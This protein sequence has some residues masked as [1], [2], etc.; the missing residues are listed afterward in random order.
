MGEYVLDVEGGSAFCV[1]FFSAWYEDGGLRAV[2]I[3]DGENGVIS[4][5]FREFSDEI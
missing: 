2:V 1:D 3:G 4:L 5:R